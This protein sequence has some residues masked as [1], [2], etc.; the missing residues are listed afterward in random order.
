M[1]TKL[2]SVIVLAIF[3]NAAIAS[4]E[5]T[6][7]WRVLGPAFAWHANADG[8]PVVS[9]RITGYQWMCAIGHDLYQGITPE[10]AAAISPASFECRGTPIKVQQKGW[11]NVN[12]AIGLERRTTRYGDY[13]AKEFVGIVKDSYGRPSAM[14]GA[15]RMWLLFEGRIRIEAGVTG[16]LWYRTIGQWSD[17]SFDRKLVPLLLPVLSV[18]DK[19]SGLGLNFSFV[20]GIRYHGTE[21]SVPTLMLQTTYRFN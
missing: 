20:P 11:T 7:E 16:L 18:D 5:S 12:P 13:A 19:A 6:V 4:V 21:Y 9:S 2:L 15:A 14:I 17:G 8:A 1:N 10:Q 3:S